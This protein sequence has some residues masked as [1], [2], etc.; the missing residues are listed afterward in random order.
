MGHHTR[1]PGHTHCTQML[2]EHASD[3]GEFLSKQCDKSPALLKDT[4]D[5]VCI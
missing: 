2:K 5:K 4:C 1:Q 3:A